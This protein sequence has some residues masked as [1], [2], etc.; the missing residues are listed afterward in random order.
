M[1]ILFTSKIKRKLLF[2]YEYIAALLVLFIVLSIFFSPSCFIKYN[3]DQGV[4]MNVAFERESYSSIKSPSKGFTDF[5]SVKLKDN[6]T[7]YR[8]Y[9]DE[10]LREY[11]EK[12]IIGKSVEL[13]FVKHKE[14]C[15]IRNLSIDGN[16]IVQTID[17]GFFPFL[18]FVGLGIICLIWSIWGFYITYLVSDEKR[19]EIL[20]M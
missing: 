13:Q 16:K 7:H 12:K 6:E 1:R 17:T 8:C 5:Y 11:G 3:Y 10:L 2:V 19:K 18:L 14:Y 4:I 9:D 20:G 15:A